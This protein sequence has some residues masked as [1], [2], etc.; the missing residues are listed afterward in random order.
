MSDGTKI[1]GTYKTINLR[2]RI[3]RTNHGMDEDLSFQRDQLDPN[4]GHEN[5]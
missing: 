1:R 3:V 2:S 5:P 4:Y